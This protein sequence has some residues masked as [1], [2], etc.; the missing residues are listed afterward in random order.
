MS[1]FFTA[2][3]FRN[4]FV[5]DRSSANISDLANRLIQERSV[6]V[7][8]YEIDGDWLFRENDIDTDDTHTAQAI[9]IKPIEKAVECDHA[10]MT[11][12]FDDKNIN[13]DRA[14]FCP[15]CGKDLKGGE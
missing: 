4:M 2:D 14:N 3:D 8:G 10:T 6:S 15:K 5:G 11:F 7:S 1:D 13:V 12:F 9:N